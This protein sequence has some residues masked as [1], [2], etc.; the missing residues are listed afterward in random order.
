YGMGVAKDIQPFMSLS[1]LA[2]VVIPEIKI[3]DR[4][5]FDVGRF[6]FTPLE[7]E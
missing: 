3:T 6:G 5:L 1:F 4:G 7:A 2:L